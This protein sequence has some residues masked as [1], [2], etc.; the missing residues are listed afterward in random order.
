LLGCSII[1][2]IAVPVSGAFVFII[3]NDNNSID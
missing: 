2:T 3:D 1:V